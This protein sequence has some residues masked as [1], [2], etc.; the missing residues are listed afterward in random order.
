M[1]RSVVDASVDKTIPVHT[2][3][4][5]KVDGQL[6]C[7]LKLKISHIAW[8]ISNSPDVTH[9]RVKWWGEDGPGTVFR[10]R[11]C[12]TIVYSRFLPSFFS[13]RLHTVIVLQ[14]VV[15]L[16]IIG[17]ESLCLVILYAVF[18]DTFS[19]SASLNTLCHFHC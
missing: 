19:I 3:L 16:D 15:Y 5:P 1:F 2:S 18:V 7:Y 4:P 9:V 8:L 6:R 12:A 17:A 13:V 11:C 10:C 14:K